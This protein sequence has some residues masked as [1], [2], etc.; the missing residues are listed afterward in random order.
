MSHY[1][2]EDQIKAI[3]VRDTYAPGAVA[4]VETVGFRSNV[5]AGPN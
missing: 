1:F 3:S 5:P 4:G 2:I